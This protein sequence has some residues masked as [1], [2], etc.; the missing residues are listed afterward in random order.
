MPAIFR[1]A[2]LAPRFLDFVFEL[3]PN[4]TMAVTAN[5]INASKRMPVTPIPGAPGCPNPNWRP[6]ITDLS[7]TTATITVERPAGNLVLTVTCTFSGPTTNGAVRGA[8]VT[9]TSS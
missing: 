2:E 1:V 6:D 8:D 4:P 5:V 9:C 7:F 3:F